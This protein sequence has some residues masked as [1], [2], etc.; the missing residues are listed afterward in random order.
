MSKD[1]NAS[2]FIKADNNSPVNNDLYFGDSLGIGMTFSDSAT[3]DWDEF[4]VV[5]RNGNN[6]R[7]TRACLFN[8][9][10]NTKDDSVMHYKQ[11]MSAI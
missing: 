8:C 10:I 3:A 6:T 9:Y 7:M 4:L 11:I 5:F 1:F 2:D